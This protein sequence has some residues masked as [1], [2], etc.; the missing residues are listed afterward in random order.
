MVESLERLDYGA[1]GRRKVEYL[2]PGLA[3]RRLENSFCQSSSKWNLFRTREGLGSEEDEW[4]PSF[5]CCVQD[6]VDILL[7]LPYSHKPKGNYYLYRFTII[8]L[9]RM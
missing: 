7:P 2:N 5:I 6:T 4:A 3:I 8:K 1:E 9:Y